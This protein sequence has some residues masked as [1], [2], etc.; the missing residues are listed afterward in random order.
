M[1][2]PRLALFA[3][4]ALTLII[5]VASVK[6]SARFGSSENV[7]NVDSTTEHDAF[8]AGNTVSIAGPI[9]G[10]AFVAGSTI[11]VTEPVGR[12]LFAAG[13]TV[14]VSKGVGYNLYAAGNSVTLNGEYGNDVYVAG[15]SVVISK[16]TVIKGDLYVS[17]SSVTLA[18]T[19]IGDVKIA[20]G[21]V[22]SSAKVGGS[23][24]GPV[25]HLQFTGGSVAGDL[26]YASKNDALGLETVAVGGKTVRSQPMEH[27]RTEAETAGS[28]LAL[29]LTMLLSTLMLAA[30]MI[31]LLPG[32]TLNAI[33]GMANNWALNMAVG[34]VALLVTPI[35][36]LVAF[37]VI[38]GWKIGLILLLLYV[39]MLL[40]AGVLTT[41]FVGSLTVQRLLPRLAMGDSV[42]VQLVIGALVL[43]VLQAIPYVGRIVTI[44][45]FTLVF[46]PA[47]GSLCT[48]ILSGMRT[49]VPEVP[50]K[51]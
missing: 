51:K 11:T 22:L 39:A 6:A 14:Q 16:D 43:A 1:R 34:A 46:I 7:L 12:S 8:L 24:H 41:L 31:A 32:L 35:L 21:T 13:N 15:S 36:A 50:K 17:G 27:G 48:S 26:T 33:T 49:P 45:V 9:K 30:V 18:G 3:L 20:A 47:V 19:V 23:F 2:L 4:L 40:A 10:E 5:P 25:D 29:S 44:L 28:N 38:I 42:W 37:G